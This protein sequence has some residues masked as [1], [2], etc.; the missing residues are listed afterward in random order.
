M[1]FKVTRPRVNYEEKF[2]NCL[3]TIK[4][5]PTLSPT[6]SGGSK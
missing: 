4:N 1:P 6:S 5:Y 2:S 3:D